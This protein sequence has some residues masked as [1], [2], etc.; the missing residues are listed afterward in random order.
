M[1][2]LICEGKNDLI[3][4]RSILSNCFDKQGYP[5]DNKMD[6]VFEIFRSKMHPFYR[7]DFQCILYCEGGKKKLFVNVIIPLIKEVFGKEDP[8]KHESRHHFFVVI[9]ADGDTSNHLNKI[10]CE[11]IKNVIKTERIGRFT[12]Q[13]PKNGFCYDFFSRTDKRSRCYVKTAYVPTSLEEQLKIEGIAHLREKR[14]TL[15]KKIQGMD[16]HEALKELAE[17]SGLSTEN[18]IILS[19]KEGWFADKDW[20][21]QICQ[22]MKACLI[23]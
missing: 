9:D 20:Y 2:C 6:K 15:T 7:D 10:Y 16:A 12:C 5:V 22:N 19:V 14:G 4:F 21:Q 11:T 1:K 23:S 17:C 8:C 18:F 13:H 3:F